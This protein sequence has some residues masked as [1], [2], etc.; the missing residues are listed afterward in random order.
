MDEINQGKLPRTGDIQRLVSR[1]KN[2][3][4][5]E[6]LKGPRFILVYLEQIM[7]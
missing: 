3:V 6:F 1:R 2:C 5:S 4:G 7:G